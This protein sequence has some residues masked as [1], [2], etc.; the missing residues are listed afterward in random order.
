[1]ERH[2]DVELHRLA[3][4]CDFDELVHRRDRTRD[5]GLLRLVVVGDLARP[6][7]DLGDQRL[8]LVESHLAQ[9]DHPA[10][11]DRHGILHAL[12]AVADQ[13]H[14]VDER[15]RAGGDVGRVLA[16]TV[17][18]R[19]V[20][21][22]TERAIGRDRDRQSARL[23]VGRQR[24]LIVRPLETELADRL[25]ERSVGLVERLARDRVTLGELLAHAGKLGTLA[26]EQKGAW[27]AVQHS[28]AHPTRSRPG[29]GIRR[30]NPDYRRRL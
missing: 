3:L 22:L 17:S 24:Q 13:P 5:H 26:S 21:L 10:G 30:A 28:A 18:G 4:R 25:G 29:F 27:H 12:G 9:R 7:V 14:G 16:E 2:A 1:M 6:G 19:E 23:G 20:R 11:A 8:D 15:Q